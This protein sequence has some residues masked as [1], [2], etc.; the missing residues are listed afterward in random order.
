MGQQ[1]QQRVNDE[2]QRVNDDGRRANDEGRRVNDE[3]SGLTN[4]VPFKAP[5]PSFEASGVVR[6]P[7]LSFVLPPK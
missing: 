5:T 1:R 6:K 3:G 4:P 2:G 7:P